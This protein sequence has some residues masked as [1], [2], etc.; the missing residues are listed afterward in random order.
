M[1]KIFEILKKSGLLFY[2]LFVFVNYLIVDMID[3]YI[4]IHTLI[5]LIIIYIVPLV[6]FIQ[7]TLK[8]LDDKKIKDF[9]NKEHLKAAYPDIPKS[10]LSDKP[11]GMVLGKYNNKYVYIPIG[12]DGLNILCTAS[13]GSG[14]SILLKAQLLANK[15]KCQINGKHSDYIKSWNYFLIDVDGLI[16]KDIY[17]VGGK[18]KATENNELQVIELNN[19]SSYGFDVFYRLHADNVTETTKLKTVTDIADALIPETKSN[20]YFS[21]NAKKILTGV[22]LYGIEKDMDFVSIIQMLL[23][24][25]LDELLTNIVTEAEQLGNSIILDKLKG[26]VG[27]A[28]NESLQDV[29]STLKQYLDV[30]SYPDVIYCLQT[31]LHKTSPQML[32]DG[33]SNLVFAVETSMLTV[34]EPIFRLITMLVLRHCESEFNEDD[35]RYTSILIDE[36]ARIGKVNDLANL[37][38]TSRKY[39]VNIMMLFQDLAQYRNIYGKEEASAILNL[40][41]LKIFLSISGDAETMELLKNTVGKYHLTKQSYKKDKVLHLQ[42]DTNYQEEEKDIIDGPSI[43]NLREKDEIIIIYFGKYFRFKKIRY[44]KDKI[45][46]PIYKEIQQ[47]NAEQKR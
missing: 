33:K 34:Y 18:Y 8:Y 7:T 41:E 38:A 43:M 13:P 1:R 37:M 21:V 39:H 40:C 4:E 28:D 32:N 27:K 35:N 20:P 23:R 44:Y 22:L 42:S 17:K 47:Y 5:K 19:R 12:R 11:K 16:Y 36:A 15:Y 2:L 26:F 29:E 3:E 46:G 10:Y 31:N 30:F 14:K 25:T 24:N 45:L 6:V 9:D